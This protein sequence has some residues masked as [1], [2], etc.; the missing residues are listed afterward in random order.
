MN[1]EKILEDIKNGKSHKEILDFL[2]E[3][4]RRF[5]FENQVKKLESDI[6]SL[7]SSIKSKKKKIEDL[8]KLKD[9]ITTF[10]SLLKVEDVVDVVDVR[11]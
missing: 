6:E 8:N 10:K 4:E 11:S 7:K 3:E 9:S 2:N 1:F 5:D